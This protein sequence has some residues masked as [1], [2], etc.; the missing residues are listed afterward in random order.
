MG[1]EKDE[2]NI[3]NDKTQDTRHK[4]KRSKRLSSIF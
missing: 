4:A 1:N 2:E 3:D